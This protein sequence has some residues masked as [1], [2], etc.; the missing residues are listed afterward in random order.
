M[1][2]TYMCKIKST[3]KWAKAKPAFV[4]INQGLKALG[5]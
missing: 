4:T 1:S 2:S 5:I 3:K